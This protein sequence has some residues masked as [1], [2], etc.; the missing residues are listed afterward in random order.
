MTGNI[1]EFKAFFH[2]NNVHHI[3][4][5]MFPPFLSFQPFKTTISISA[6]G[7]DENRLRDDLGGHAFAV[8]RRHGDGPRISNYLLLTLIIR[9]FGCVTK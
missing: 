4:L 5:R 1:I 3:R 2:N 8:G 7:L 6:R 9:I